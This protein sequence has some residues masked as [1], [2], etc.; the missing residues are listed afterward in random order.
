M[1]RWSRFSSIETC[2]Q[3]QFRNQRPGQ[4][5]VDANDEQVGAQACPRGRRE[6][7]SVP[8]LRT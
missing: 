6:D 3:R 4:K 2:N 7:F 8:R 1:T 5:H